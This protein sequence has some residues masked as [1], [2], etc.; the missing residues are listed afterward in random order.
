MTTRTSDR[1][2]ALICPVCTKPNPGVAR[3]CARCGFG[4]QTQ[5]TGSIRPG[6]FPHPRPLSI[7][8][9]FMPCNGAVDLFF[10]Y[11]PAWGGPVLSGT[12]AVTVEI[13]NAGFPMRE[14]A[15]SVGMHDLDGAYRE[16]CTKTIAELPSGRAAKVE[17][18][19]YELGEPVCDVVVSLT[20]AE[21][22]FHDEP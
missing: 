16:C 19:S 3:Y 11:A 22:D 5:V 20:S 17:I 8:D 7:P 21:F 9:G 6:R 15:L 14:V 4:L 10:R 1:T 12:E 2:A 13:Y 18:A